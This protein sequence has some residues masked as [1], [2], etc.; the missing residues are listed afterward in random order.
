MLLDLKATVDTKRRILVADSCFQRKEYLPACTPVF[1]LE[2]AMARLRDPQ[3]KPEVSWADRINEV[4]S[5]E[6]AQLLNNLSQEWRLDSLSS[7]Q[8]MYRLARVMFAAEMEEIEKELHYLY[9]SWDYRFEEG[10]DCTD[11]AEEKDNWASLELFLC[12]LVQ[13]RM[14]KLFGDVGGNISWFMFAK[15]I[16]IRPSIFVSG[17]PIDPTGLIDDILLD[18]SRMHGTA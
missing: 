7:D 13:L 11:C 8:R 5:I 17:R 6:A 3:Y 14:T 16:A 9:E 1:S 10:M 18:G 12:D 2:V 4:F 15:T